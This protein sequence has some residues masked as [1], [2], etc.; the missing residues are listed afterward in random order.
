MDLETMV[1]KEMKTMVISDVHIPH[2][3]EE[4]LKATLKYAKIYKPDNF[5]I[6]GDYVD[7]YN[8]SKFDK[9]PERKFTIPDELKQ[10]QEVL[11][12][13][14]NVLPRSCNKVF[15]Q[16]NHENR[17]QGYIWRN[18]ELEGLEELKLT[19]LLKLKENG[20]KEVKVDRE[21]WGEETGHYKVG[22]TIIMHGDSRLNGA[23][24]SI[25]SG[26]S[27]H[28][29]MTNLMSSVVLGH[30]HRGAV[31]Y[32]RTPIGTITGIEN[33]CLCKIPGNADWQH[34]FSTFETK[35]GKSYN[36]QF[37]KVD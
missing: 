5:V 28:N 37:H 33:G 34:G 6:S 13:I 1:K 30:V 18:P 22:D 12:R 8:L 24:T 29:T 17:L 36:Y 35:K 15:I 10:A 20:F 3:D 31:V 11:N 16:G 25:K 7:F 9:N 23:K 21:Y 27:A 4:A 14:S 19:K 26:Y 2:H 32:H